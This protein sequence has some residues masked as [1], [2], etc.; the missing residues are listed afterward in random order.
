MLLKARDT[1]RVAER[2]L[3][4]QRDERARAV[5][6]FNFSKTVRHIDPDDIEQ[7]EEAKSR[8]LSARTYFAAHEP[9]QLEKVDAAG[10]PWICLRAPRGSTGAST[11]QAAIRP[12]RRPPRERSSELQ[13]TFSAYP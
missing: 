8:L 6:D 3:R 2:L 13:S 4:G 7:L 1:Y 11:R 5:L 12:A 10:R 9:V